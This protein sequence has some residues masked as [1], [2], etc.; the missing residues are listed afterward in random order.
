MLAKPLDAPSAGARRRGET[1]YI[2]DCRR[3]SSTHSQ[4]RGGPADREKLLVAI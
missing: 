4:M 3:R 2:F 1:F